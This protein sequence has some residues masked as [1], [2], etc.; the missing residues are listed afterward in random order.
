M[1]STH[2][3]GTESVPARYRGLASGLIG[4]GGAGIGALIASITYLIMSSIFPGAAFDVWGWRCMFF[5]GILS[6]VLGVFIFSMLE[7]SPLWKHVAEQK[8]LAAAARGAKGDF[9]Q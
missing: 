2:T 8:R 6:S 5:T 4:G 7:E 9:V 3:I 1:A